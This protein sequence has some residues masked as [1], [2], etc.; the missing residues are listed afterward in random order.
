MR[1]LPVLYKSQQR[2][3][4]CLRLHFV[5]YGQCCGER[6]HGRI[7]FCFFCFPPFPPLFKNT[8]ARI[9]KF[10][11]MIITTAAVPRIDG[12]GRPVVIE[13]V[14]NN[15]K[16]AIGTIKGPSTG[17]WAHSYAPAHQISAPARRSDARR[18]GKHA[19][20]QVLIPK[21]SGGLYT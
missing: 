12:F 18:N 6:Q 8:H 21:Q 3:S 5:I 10:Y 14:I 16:P 19:L 1:A 4:G 17:H 2:S 7:I 15:R 20:C 13:S 11:V 9:H